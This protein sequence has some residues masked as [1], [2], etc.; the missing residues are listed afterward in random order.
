MKKM[1]LG[2]LVLISVIGIVA[3]KDIQTSDKGMLIE[4][5]DNTGYYL[6]E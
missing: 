2:A 3:I 4:F 6:G 1:L 5:R